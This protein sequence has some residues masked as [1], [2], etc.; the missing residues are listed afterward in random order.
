MMTGYLGQQDQGQQGRGKWGGR[1][2]LYAYIHAQAEK[3][4]AGA[5]LA[6]AVYAWPVSEAYGSY[7]FAW[8][9]PGTAALEAEFGRVG[10]ANAAA[11]VRAAAAAEGS[12]GSPDVPTAGGWQGA[13]AEAPAPASAAAAET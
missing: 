12:S 4:G 7:N 6:W 1:D 10:R 8:G 11:A 9:S 5:T 2:E 13:G 3:V